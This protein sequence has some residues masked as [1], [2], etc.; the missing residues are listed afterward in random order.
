MGSCQEAGTPF[1]EQRIGVLLAYPVMD[2]D[3]LVAQGEVSMLE[4]GLSV[5]QQRM[6]DQA[7]K[8]GLAWFG[9]FVEGLS[10]TRV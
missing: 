8:K 9:Y 6:L 7:E 3:M 10:Y 5:L 2:E 1:N 4:S